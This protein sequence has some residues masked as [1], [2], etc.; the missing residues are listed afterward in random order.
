MAE[1]VGQHPGGIAADAQ[2]AVVQ[3]PDWDQLIGEAVANSSQP[4]MAETYLS[5]WNPSAR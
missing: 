4:I 2:A 3:L 1:G 5:K